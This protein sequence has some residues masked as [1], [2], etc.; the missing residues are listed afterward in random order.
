M[1]FQS[2][3]ITEFLLV[4]ITLDLAIINTR[5][6][7]RYMPVLTVPAAHLS[8]PTLYKSQPTSEKLGGVVVEVPDSYYRCMIY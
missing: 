1:Y 7:A 5:I 8:Q 6:C 2:T 4:C 3:G